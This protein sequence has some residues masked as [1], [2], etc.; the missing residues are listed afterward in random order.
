MLI[1]LSPSLDKQEIYATGWE[2]T[3]I[4]GRKSEGEPLL[5]HTFDH[6]L[7]ITDN[8]RI[9]NLN[10]TL[11]DT[12]FSILTSRPRMVEYDGVKVFWND[13][14]KGVW[15]PSIDTVLMA[16]ALRGVITDNKNTQTAIE[17]GCGSG[18]LSKYLLKKSPNL[19][20]LTI[21]DINPYAIQCARDN[22]KDTRASYVVGD[23]LK[24]IKGKTYD[25]IV[26]N[27][28]YIPRPQS[29]E[30]NPYEGVSLLNYF[31]HHGQD[32]LSSGGIIVLGT[33]NL[34][35]E[36]VFNK[37]SKLE[38]K[39]L[40]EME[41]PLKINNVLNSADW[42]SYL[43]SRNL[44]KHHHDGYEFWHRIKTISAQNPF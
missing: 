18:F 42:I 38:F 11:R 4:M 32:H 12:L 24:E 34:S 19:K 39:T 17:I 43:Q 29:V 36:L 13:S 37:K 7:L 14:H 9:A 20:S 25:L 6:P 40:E 5:A 30:I 8:Y 1:K 21:N 33:S 22:I 26:C 16:K 3:G 28:P 44:K 31:V 35:D 27:P 15:S 41:V 2:L 23:G 10:P